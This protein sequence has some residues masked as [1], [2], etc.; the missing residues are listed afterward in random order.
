MF[1]N[2]S[3]LTSIIIPKSVTS[4]GDSALF[5]TSSLSSVTFE[6]GSTLASIGPMAF[7]NATSL[8]SILIPNSVTSIGND[9]FL[10]SGLI[11]ATV[12]YNRFNTSNFPAGIG[13]NQTI[14]D[15]YPVTII[16]YN[17]PLNLT[18][19]YTATDSSYVDISGSLDSGDLPFSVANIT[20]VAIGNT[21]TSIGI[22][23]F[24]STSALTS[25]TFEAGPTL[26]TIGN[27][28]FRQTGLTS[29]E[30][31][32][33]VTSIGNYAF[34]NAT[35][36]TTVTFEA[37]SS[38]T[39]ISNNAFQQSVLLTSIIIPEQVITIGNDA[40]LD[41]GLTTAT[42]N[43][44]RLGTSNFPLAIGPNQTIG[45]KYPVFIIGYNIPIK[46]VYNRKNE[47]KTMGGVNQKTEP[48]LA[49]NLNM[50]KN[51]Y[52]G[53]YNRGRNTNI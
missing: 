45:G 52:R 35:L 38:L 7:Q 17:F 23:T 18:V 32:K 50:L 37:D 9:A 13:E 42:V 51:K 15:K 24:A 46:P 39:T 43:Y 48:G 14:G 21:V 6:A 29:I 19:F 5:G 53:S 28:A 26:T 22:N 16:G 11:E 47:N 8:T 4:I 36:L 12:N 44:A 20:Q 27:N 30:I 49:N 41:S 40:F 2:A 34:Y 1:Q 31:P 10:S 25:V 3:G 33:S